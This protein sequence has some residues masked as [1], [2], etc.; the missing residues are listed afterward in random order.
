M[1]EYAA[2]SDGAQR[3]GAKTFSADLAHFRADA[4]PGGKWVLPMGAEG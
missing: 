3:T 1:A 2:L 4:E